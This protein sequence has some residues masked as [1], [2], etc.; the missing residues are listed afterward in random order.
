MD[1]QKLIKNL[2]K[3]GTI[4][5]ID[6]SKMVYLLPIGMSCFCD[7]FDQLDHAV[8]RGDEKLIPEIINLN[9]KQLTKKQTW[10]DL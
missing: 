4:K 1:I 7:N 10:M 8:N 9:P 3:V 6:E 5:D 2:K